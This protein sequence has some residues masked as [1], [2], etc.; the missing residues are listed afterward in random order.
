MT[1]QEQLT[2]YRSRHTIRIDRDPVHPI[3][4][5]QTDRI[6]VVPR[7]RGWRHEPGEIERLAK[8]AR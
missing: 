8:A 1:P 3:F 2:L 6:R 5:C 4:R 7:L